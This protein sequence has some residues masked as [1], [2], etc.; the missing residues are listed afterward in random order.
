MS[1]QLAEA[2]A[3]RWIRLE[4]LPAA[5]EERKKGAFAQLVMATVYFAVLA[6][7]FLSWPWDWPLWFKALCIFLGGVWGG[8]LLSWL[9]RWLHGR[10]IRGVFGT[11]SIWSMRRT[12]TDQPFTF[13]AQQVL[14]KPVH[15]DRLTVSLAYVEPIFSVHN[16]RSRS[17]VLLARPPAV[18]RGEDDCIRR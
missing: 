6:L 7:S 14:K 8:V 2:G 11:C 4:V 18:D 5:A 13:R 3:S 12:S 16:D 17:D 9:R 1:S 10:K 15:V